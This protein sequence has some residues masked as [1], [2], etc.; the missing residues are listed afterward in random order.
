MAIATITI[1]AGGEKLRCQA[2]ESTT[3]AFNVSNDTGERLRIS[4]LIAAESPAEPDWFAVDGGNERDLSAGI[5][6]QIVARLQIP[7]NSAPG[8]YAFRLQVY[9]T[10]D[11]EKSVQSPVVALEIPAPEQKPEP[12]PEPQPK[13]AF[14]WLIVAVVAGVLLLGGGV[15][16]WFLTR[17]VQVPDV[18]GQD[19]KAATEVIEQAG[20]SVAQPP[21]TA[22][23]D[24]QS[25]DTVLDQSPEA[26][27][28]VKKGT[29]I[30]LT[31]A[32]PVQTAGETL[33]VASGLIKKGGWALLAD[34]PLDCSPAGRVIFNLNNHEQTARVDVKPSGEVFWVAGGKGHSWV[35]LD[36]VVL[37]PGE[38]GEDLA[39]KNGWV[40]YG[41]GYRKAR[42]ARVGGL[43][44]VSGLIKG[45][46][47]ST[48]AVLP[49][50]CHPSRRLI[51]NLNNH[52]NTARVDV[53]PSGE[54]I[55][56]T[57]G[58]DHGWI[59]LDGI[60]FEPGDGGDPLPLHNN[61]KNHSS[62]YRGARVARM[63]DLCVVSGLIK[64]TN[65]GTVAVLP[66]PCRPAGRLIFNLNNHAKTARVD[67]KKTGEILWVAGG[68]DHGWISLTGIV[69]RSG[70]GGD[71]VL[72]LNN[73]VNYGGDY[74]PAAVSAVTLPDAAR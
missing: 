34:L 3:C 42:V 2:G 65:W 30:A 59:N 21:R 55:W 12:R 31:V 72:L 68:K 24:Q 29:E 26:G 60:V 63:G 19:L 49:Q 5:S 14:P 69:F 35:S 46:A 43:C 23:T 45:G 54:V 61:W 11:P 73:W 53:L 8:R 4:A 71:P 16:A 48:L 64:G 10:D 47:W 9:S 7:R 41:G 25:P 36:G 52:A 62:T 44:V 58:K 56:V 20:L 17:G 1:V 70:K 33:C 27:D 13:P 22:E 37:K 67:V 39:L 57:G 6:D 32:T 38:G 28:K 15:A 66:E 18:I 74:R 40:D 50:D 51:F